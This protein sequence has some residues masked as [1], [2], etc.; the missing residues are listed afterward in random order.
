M[1]VINNAYNLGV[2]AMSFISTA[3]W[4]YKLL[5]IIHDYSLCP[6]F[7]D[8]KENKEEKDDKNS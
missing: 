5:D 6:I 3:S 4:I 2:F 7:G 8:K 1:L